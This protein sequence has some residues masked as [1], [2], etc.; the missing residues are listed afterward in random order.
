MIIERI[1]KRIKFTLLGLGI[2]ALLTFITIVVLISVYYD[3][4]SYPNDYAVV[5]DAGSSSSKMYV[6]TWKSGLSANEGDEVVVSEIYKCTKYPGIDK[7]KTKEDTIIYFNDCLQNA[8]KKVPNE[9]K[10]RAHILL[11]ATAG[12]RLLDASDKE[13]TDKIIDYIRK[14]FSNSEFLYKSDNQVKVL[15]GKEEGLYGW[16]TANYFADKFSSKTDPV[17]TIGILDM[18]GA[19][20]QISFVPSGKIQNQTIINKFYEKSK[21][22]GVDYETYSHSFLCWGVNEFQNIY[23]TYLVIKSNYQEKVDAPCFNLNATIDFSSAS[24][25]DSNCANGLLFKYPLPINLT[26]ISQKKFYAL[27][28]TS[29]PG[30]CA[31]EI[32]ALLPDMN[33]PYGS[34]KCSFNQAFLPDLTDKNKFYAFSNFYYKLANTEM[35][36]GQKLMKNLDGLKLESEKL[37]NLSFLELTDINQKL[38]EKIFEDYLKSTCFFNYYLLT[39]FSRYRITKFDNVEFLTK[40]NGNSI[41]W[42][43]G[44]MIDLINRA[45]FLPYESPPRKLQPEFFIPAI[46]ICSVFTILALISVLFCVFGL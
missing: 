37:L 43:L 46:I 39:I 33:C 25:L 24:I 30:K 23:Q 13:Q 29:D 42:S 1:N 10:N 7:L 26:A 2:I 32:S 12:M 27:N 4:Y 45:D 3:S 8:S 18:G 5:F 21:I 11:A 35:L 40:V 34:N 38:D 31:Q 41:G 20:T 16:I 6:Y 17:S 19:S 14:H 9:R 15:T 44:Y 28:G 22:Y 36:S